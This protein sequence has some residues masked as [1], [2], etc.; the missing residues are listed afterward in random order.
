MLKY[1][2]K[3]FQEAYV[4][5][6]NLAEATRFLANE[7]FGKTGLVTIDADDSELKKEF[8]PYAKERTFTRQTSHQK[9][10]ETSENLKDYNIQVESREINLFY[11]EVL[12]ARTNHFSG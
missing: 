1:L 6:S 4:K 8:I 5:H 7:I 3:L 2:R 12:R 11:I 9:V 10:L